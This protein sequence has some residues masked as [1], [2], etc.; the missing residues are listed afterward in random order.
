MA[1]STKS[2]HLDDP[3]I[4]S[5]G[6]VAIGSGR[7]GAGGGFGEGF[8]FGGG[9]GVGRGIGK[10]G[11]NVGWVLWFSASCGLMPC[12][13]RRPTDGQLDARG[14]PLLPDDRR[15]VAGGQMGRFSVKNPGDRH[16]KLGGNEVGRNLLPSWGRSTTWPS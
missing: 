11:R 3:A 9:I 2:S 8:G 5:I 14:L 1:S 13:L 15:E 16:T 4:A 10:G 12:S 7:R 6:P